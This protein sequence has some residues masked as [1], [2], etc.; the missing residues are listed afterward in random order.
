MTPDARLDLTPVG[1]RR[2][3][4]AVTA[5]GFAGEIAWSE[6]VCFPPSANYLFFTSNN[7]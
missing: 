1:Y 5:A 6:T 2:I 4:A 3:R 7:N